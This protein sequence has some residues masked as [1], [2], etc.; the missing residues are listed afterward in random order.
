[1]NKLTDTG[2]HF[3]VQC[4][5]CEGTLVA[6]SDRLTVVV[7]AAQAHFAADHDRSLTGKQV[8][9]DKTLIWRIEEA[10]VGK[11]IFDRPLTGLSFEAILREVTRESREA[12]NLPQL[13]PFIAA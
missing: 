6:E 10:I 1:M 4:I 12:A 8:L 9:E 3:R 11:K 7:V 2:L 13:A 5:M